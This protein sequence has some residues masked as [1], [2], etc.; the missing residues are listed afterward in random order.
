MIRS[1]I[2]DGAL[3]PGGV[4]VVSRAMEAADSMLDKPNNDDLAFYLPLCTY[5]AKVCD[6][7]M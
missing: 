1:R 5:N 2:Q 3:T 7:S 4:S 6:P